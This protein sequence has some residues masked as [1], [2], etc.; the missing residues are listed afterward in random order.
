MLE[1]Y[2]Y[3]NKTLFVD[4]SYFT[5]II[6]LNIGFYSAHFTM[7][8]QSV[9]GAEFSVK[10][11]SQLT[12]NTYFHIEDL[13]PIKM[14]KDHSTTSA[15]CPPEPFICIF[16][17]SLCISRLFLCLLGHTSSTC[18]ALSNIQMKE[19]QMQKSIAEVDLWL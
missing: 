6:R 4:I 16:T 5:Y 13:S 18:P 15:H 8:H 9:I 10:H 19:N 3:N 14:P 1:Y 12:L 17:I 7:S 2:L 11:H